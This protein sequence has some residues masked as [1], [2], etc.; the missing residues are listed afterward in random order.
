VTEIVQ[1]KVTID[2]I[3]Y[4]LMIDI[5]TSLDAIFLIIN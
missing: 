1:H 5:S 3:I 4:I 2:Y